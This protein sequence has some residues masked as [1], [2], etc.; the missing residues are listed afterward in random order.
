M[1]A[2]LS[3]KSTVLTTLLLTGFIG[4]TPTLAQPIVSDQ[5]T[6]TI[7]TPNGNQ[8]DIS[9]GTLSGDGA[10][11]F[12]SFQKLGL[13]S[14]ETANFLSNPTIQN[15]LGRVRVEMPRLLMD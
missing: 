14:G 7:V 13:N 6:G 5:T 1:Q 2:S 11:L 4:I 12:H 15:I 10:N 3:L 9:G 8:L